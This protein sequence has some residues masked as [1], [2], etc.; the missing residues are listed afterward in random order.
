MENKNAVTWY[1]VNMLLFEVQKA[2][3]KPGEC[4]GKASATKGSWHSRQRVSPRPHDV[5]QLSGESFPRV[6]RDPLGRSCRK[7]NDDY[8]VNRGSAPGLHL[9]ASHFA[10]LEKNGA[11]RGAGSTTSRGAVGAHACIPAAKEWGRARAAAALVAPFQAS[12]RVRE[13]S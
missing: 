8:T 5:Q 7:L 2:P 6:A 12:P 3:D 11:P 1:R 9:G 13:L 10:I 4:E